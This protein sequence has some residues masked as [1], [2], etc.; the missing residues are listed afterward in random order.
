MYN[1]FKAFKDKEEQGRVT[2]RIWKDDEAYE[3]DWHVNEDDAEQENERTLIRMTAWSL[4]PT[5]VR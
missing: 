3:E 5:A 4:T 2:I 1:P